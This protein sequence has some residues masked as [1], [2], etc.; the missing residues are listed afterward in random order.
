MGKIT[1]TW[2]LMS[3]CWQVLRQDKGLL[4]FPLLS[5]ICCLALIASF[6]IPLYTTGHWEPPRRDAGSSQ[7]VAYYGMLF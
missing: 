7:Q 1:R 3:D 4:L 5:G 2:S 6:A